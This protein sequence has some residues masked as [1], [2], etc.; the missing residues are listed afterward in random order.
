[1]TREEFL[2]L[3]EKG[4]E[5]VFQVIEALEARIK[6]LEDRLAQNSHN[7]SK[8]PSTDGY[9]KPSPKTLRQPSG[10]K[11]GGQ[12]GHPGHTLEKVSHP[13]HFEVHRVQE[14]EVC[15]RD[16]RNEPASGCETRQEFDMPEL[17]ITVTEHQAEIKTCPGC[18]HVNTAAFPER[19]AQPVQYGPRI[20]AHSVYLS[21]YQLLP[22]ERIQEYFRDVFQCPVSPGTLVQF[23]QRCFESLEPVDAAIKQGVRKAEVVHFDE[24]GLRIGG[25]RKWL[26][27]A[28]TPTLTYYA[29]H[30]KRG[31]EAMEDIGILPRFHGRAIHDHWSPYF[32]YDCAHGLCNAHHLRELT[33]IEERFNQPWAQDMK[34]LLV[35]THRKCHGRWGIPQFQPV[36]DSPGFWV[37]FCLFF[38]F[39]FDFLSFLTGSFK[40]FISFLILRGLVPGLLP[41]FLPGLIPRQ[42]S[43]QVAMLRTGDWLLWQDRTSGGEEFIAQ[44][45]GADPWPGENAAGFVVACSTPIPAPRAGSTPVAAPHAK[46]SGR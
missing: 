21:Q 44:R 19:V 13:H 5:A 2:E 41:H 25:E 26:H 7:S 35:D 39:S 24:T 22:Y 37:F 33:Y 36:C 9:E 16:L 14:C 20:Q 32:A 15:H 6:A 29:P 46:S 45:R 11:P 30:P 27:L 28:S 17:K 43:S 40:E 12:E 3:Y 1:V 42:A 31:Q 38:P 18:G 23:N 34:A 8:P 10:R 4:P